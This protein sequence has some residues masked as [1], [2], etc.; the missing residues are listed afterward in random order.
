M[1]TLHVNGLDDLLIEGLRQAHRC[2]AG[3]CEPVVWQLKSQQLV[4]SNDELA[5]VAPQVLA[6]GG[7]G[8]DL[9]FRG[10]FDPVFHPLANF[11]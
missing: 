4:G 9:Q 7:Q 6:R 5:G 3:H 1:T 10:I 8:L 2:A 11:L